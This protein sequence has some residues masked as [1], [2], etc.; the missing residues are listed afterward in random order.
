LAVVMSLFDIRY[1]DFFGSGRKKTASKRAS[2]SG[3]ASNPPVKKPSTV[4]HPENAPRMINNNGFPKD[5]CLYNYAGAT[6]RVLTCKRPNGTSVRRPALVAK[7]TRKYR[8][9][10]SDENVDDGDAM[11]E[12]EMT[13]SLC[14]LRQGKHPHSD[15]I[16]A[17]LT[18]YYENKVAQKED[19]AETKNCSDSKEPTSLFPVN[20][21][22]MKINSSMEEE[23]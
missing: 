14:D 9:E 16:S 1:P 3:D 11:V 21:F 18:M 2:L 22:Y 19:P 23:I 5:F 6:L 20:D 7:M 17:A 15:A 4:V 12:M 13:A 8:L 10:K